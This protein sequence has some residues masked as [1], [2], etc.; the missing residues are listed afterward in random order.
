MFF[1][2]GKDD[3]EHPELSL[4]ILYKLHEE[5]SPLFMIT[6]SKKTLENPIQSMNLYSADHFDC[7]LMFSEPSQESFM[8]QSHEWVR[9]QKEQEP[10]IWA[11]PLKHHPVVEESR[12]T[13]FGTVMGYRYQYH[14]K[15]KTEDIDLSYVLICFAPQ[16]TT[17]SLFL[18]VESADEALSVHMYRNNKHSLSMTNLNHD[19]PREQ[20]LSIAKRQLS[21]VFEPT[22]PDDVDFPIPILQLRFG[23]INMILRQEQ[24]YEHS[25]LVIIIST[26][27]F[28]LYSLVSI[29]YIGWFFLILS[30][31]C[32]LISAA[33]A[34]YSYA[35]LTTNYA[36]RIPASTMLLLPFFFPQYG[37]ALFLFLMMGTPLFLRNAIVS[38]GIRISG[39]GI[40]EDDKLLLV[41]RKMHFDQKK[42]NEH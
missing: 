17:P 8:E 13:D 26:I 28:I 16:E 2:L 9:V 36:I 25:L 39:N 34:T 24:M 10:K 22:L 35:S 3:V 41:A 7:R 5:S 29:P 38:K 12:R 4:I 18:Y 15:A 21:T 42:N 27:G 37:P 1:L 32:W 11:P 6:L 23:D 30:G 14:E 33:H 40:Q 31:F 20:L 19:R